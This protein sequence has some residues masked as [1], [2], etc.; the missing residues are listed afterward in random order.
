MDRYFY[1]VELDD[2][3]NKVVHL[4]G[5]VYF[6]DCSEDLEQDHRYAEYCG[7]YL[8]VSEIAELVA[9]NA[10][11]ETLYAEVRYE[12]YL[13]EKVAIETCNDFFDGEPG[14]CLHIKNVNEDT[15]CGDYWFDE[16]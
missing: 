13:T 12:G 5:N 2:N 4:F 14:S 10:L 15:P 8:T 9:K 7:L 6:H 1:S 16:D 11:F 3:G